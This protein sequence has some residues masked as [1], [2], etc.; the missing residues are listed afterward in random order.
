MCKNVDC[1]PNKNK[2]KVYVNYGYGSFDLAS[3]IHNTRCGECKNRLTDV[4][5]IGF[6]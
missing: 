3:L 4:V 5:N 1:Q 6:I 2:E